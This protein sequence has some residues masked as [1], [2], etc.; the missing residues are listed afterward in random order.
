MPYYYC[1]VIRL[2]CVKYIHLL[3]DQRSHHVVISS[4]YHIAILSHDHILLYDHM[5]TLLLSYPRIYYY[6]NII[7]LHYRS[8]VSACTHNIIL[9]YCRITVIIVLYYCHII[10]RFYY[11]QMTPAYYYTT[12]PSSYQIIVLRDCR[13]IILSYFISQY[14]YIITFS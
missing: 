5:F 9:S 8:V 6:C 13:F 7:E 1:H 3:E 10:A 14:F 11:H 2:L 12:T 4:E